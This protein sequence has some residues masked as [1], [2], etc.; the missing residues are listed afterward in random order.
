MSQ[1][2]EGE[3]EN[4]AQGWVP[5]GRARAILRYNAMY[6]TK[7]DPDNHKG[8]VVKPPENTYKDGGRRRRGSK[9]TSRRRRSRARA[10]RRRGRG[11]R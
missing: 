11:A 3:K 1:L 7:Y 9:L 4:L 5:V 8:Y 2:T 10:S 6:G